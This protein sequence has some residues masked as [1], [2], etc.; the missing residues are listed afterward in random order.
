VNWTKNIEAD[1]ATKNVNSTPTMFINGK[2]LDQAH[3]LNLEALKADF[4]ALGVK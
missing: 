3:Y 1:A 4:A 2:Q